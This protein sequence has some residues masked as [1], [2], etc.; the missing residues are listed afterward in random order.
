MT[1][2]DTTGGA[3]KVRTGA[4]LCGALSYEVGA[5]FGPI[6]NCHCP[7]CR[8]AHGAAFTTVAI[9]VR[10]SFRW[11]Q[12]SGE[13]AIFRTPQGSIRHFCAKCASPI[14]NFPVEPSIACIVVASLNE[15]LE[16]LPWAHVNIESMAP[17][18]QIGDDLP[19]YPEYPDLAELG[20][21]ARANS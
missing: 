1:A 12:N 2:G 9:A 16:R 8:R 11:T 6:W 21:L 5:T 18:F 20:E 17:W 19:Q 7:F 4:C 15:P 14:C 13:P 3:G 10:S